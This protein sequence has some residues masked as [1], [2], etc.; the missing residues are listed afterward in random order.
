M[1]ILLL[2]QWYPPEPMKL[3]SD[4]AI[5]LKN[6]G[7][8]VTVLTGFPNWP[9]GRLYVGYRLRPWRKEMMDGI[10]VIR[11]CLY[12]NHSSSP[13]G[14]ILNLG[15]FLV[16]SV[17][18][19]AFLVP[20]PEVI[21]A[22]QPPTVGC[23]ACLLSRLWRV[24]FTYEVQDM[25]PESLRA[26]RLVRNER[27]LSWVARFTMWVQRR[28]A[29]IRVIS[30]GF[31]ASLVA[32]GVPGEKVHFI[33]NWVDTEYYRP[34]KPD[35]VLARELGTEG[36][37]NVMYA[38]VVGL[39][40]GL[41]V[42][43]E[44]AALLKD[45]QQVQFVLVGDGTE[46]PRLEKAARERKLDN[47]AFLGRRPTPEMP[48]LYALADALLVYLRDD[49]LF[50]ITIPHKTFTCLASGKPIL[51]ALRGDAAEIVQGANAGI[52]C[53]PGS[54]ESLA[55]AVRKLLA[56]A[57]AERKAMG[58]NGRIAACRSYS[59]EVLVPQVGRMI[60]LVVGNG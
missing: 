38:G 55:A 51:A 30:P 46:L 33:S 1:R 35:H 20:R 31:Q 29:G 41:D 3:F 4:L 27:A 50:R 45:V 7:H 44:A 2:T 54:S 14:R 9:S 13:L 56:M 24:P 37:F 15:S 28:A 6:L 36:R 21:H 26:S 43:L 12:P 10:S 32:K 52:L 8:E 60:E 49:P 5:G 23:A 11:V 47:V 34:V 42:V 53:E 57:P 25:W 22:V 48:G 16:S 58:R 17:L 39:S 40:Q 18:L 59:R 19:G